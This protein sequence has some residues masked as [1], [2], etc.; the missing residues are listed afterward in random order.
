M[1]IKA[2]AY[3][4]ILHELVTREEIFHAMSCA[5]RVIAQRLENEAKETREVL[6]Q[7]KKVCSNA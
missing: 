2:E 4:E 7:V 1:K 6:E 5:L 3:E